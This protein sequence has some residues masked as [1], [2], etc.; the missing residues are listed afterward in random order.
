MKKTIKEIKE[1]QKYRQG[2]SKEQVKSHYFG[3]SISITG[4]I[5]LFLYR[6]LFHI[7]N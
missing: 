6:L 7:F 4:I 2:R 3:A 1:N 5:L